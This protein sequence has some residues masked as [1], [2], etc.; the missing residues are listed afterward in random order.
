MICLDLTDGS[1]AVVDLVHKAMFG[2]EGLDGFMQC[3]SHDVSFFH[4]LCRLMKINSL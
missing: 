2:V 3:R 4:L 1:F